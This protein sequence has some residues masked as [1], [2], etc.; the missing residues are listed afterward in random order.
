MFA[1]K[2][3]RF[4]NNFTSSQSESPMIGTSSSS[5]YD[6]G[7]ASQLLPSGGRKGTT[8]RVD[9]ALWWLLPFRAHR[10]DTDVDNHRLSTRPLVPIAVDTD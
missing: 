4:L 7:V 1:T 9:A 5:R 2:V 3:P 8:A 6:K 10:L